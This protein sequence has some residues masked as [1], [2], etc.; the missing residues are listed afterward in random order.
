MQPVYC[1]YNSSRDISLPKYAAKDE[2]LSHTWLNWQPRQSGS[3]I[4]QVAVNIQSIHF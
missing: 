2:E 3:K 1:N 4:C